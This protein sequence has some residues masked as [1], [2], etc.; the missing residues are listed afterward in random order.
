[1]NIL[2]C[3][4]QVPDSNEIKI[5][6]ETNTLMRQGVPSIVNPFDGYALEAAARIKDKDADGTRIVVLSMGPQQAEVALRECLAIAAD[7]AYL[8]TD[9]KFGGSDTL[10]TSY[11]LSKAI[12]KV[13]ELEGRKFDAIFCGKQATDG[14]TAQVGPELAEHLGYPQVTYGLEVTAESDGLHVCREAEDGTEIIGVQT[15]CLVTFT[16]PSFD[17]RFPTIKRKL[18]ARKQ[19]IPHLTIEELTNIDQTHIGLKGS[20][21]RVKRTFV[22]PRKKSGV[23]IKEET[24]EASAQKLYEM[25]CNA[26]VI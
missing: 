5:D 14:D 2:V 11:I 4:K 18:A 13:E 21:T 7:K 6:P 15:P 19:E 22:P 23:V 24:G 1:M 9:R 20:P 10:A 8:V 26:H 16:K 3:V 17:P 25:L 12:E